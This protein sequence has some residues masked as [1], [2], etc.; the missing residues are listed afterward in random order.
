MLAHQ[1]F[2]VQ[3]RIPDLKT[4]IHTAETTLLHQSLH[5]VAQ[6]VNC[7]IHTRVRGGIQNLTL[8]PP[9]FYRVDWMNWEIVTN[10]GG[11]YGGPNVLP[12]TAAQVRALGNMILWHLHM[13]VLDLENMEAVDIAMGTLRDTG[14][15][16]ALVEADYFVTRMD[17]IRNLIDLLDTDI[18]MASIE[19][20]QARFADPHLSQNQLNELLDEL[21]S[22]IATM[23]LTLMG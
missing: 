2:V 3:I 6:T 22:Y 1:Y 4:W 14:C 7:S 11:E 12:Y 21:R 13:V 10:L 9:P 15:S 20:F 18:V 5:R 16:R 19:E 23:L 8:L 17:A